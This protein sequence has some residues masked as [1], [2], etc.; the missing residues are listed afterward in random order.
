MCEIIYDKQ[1]SFPLGVISCIL[2]K[3][4]ILLASYKGGRTPPYQLPI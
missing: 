3:T 1:F 2:L 4:V